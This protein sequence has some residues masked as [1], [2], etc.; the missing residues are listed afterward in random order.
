[1]LSKYVKNIRLIVSRNHFKVVLRYRVEMSTKVKIP[2]AFEKI[3]YRQPS[4]SLKAKRPSRRTLPHAHLIKWKKNLLN[5]NREC[6]SWTRYPG[7][8]CKA[9]IIKNSI[10]SHRLSAL[11]FMKLLFNLFC[12]AAAIYSVQRIVSFD[13][14]GF[15]VE[16][17][18]NF[19]TCNSERNSCMKTKSEQLLEVKIRI[20][21]SCRSKLKL[22]ANFGIF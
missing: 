18:I 9:I 8:Y 6:Q 2:Q 19:T 21:L 14:F 7:K 4:F 5:E 22:K 13:A 1:M 20:K 10:K 17:K 15:A 16:P 11:F 3:N 12:R